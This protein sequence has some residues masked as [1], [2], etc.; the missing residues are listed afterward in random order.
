M[1]PPRFAKSKGWFLK[2]ARQNIEFWLCS[3]RM[4]RS[5]L[6]IGDPLLRQVAA[7]VERE[8]IWTPPFQTLIDDMIETMRSANGA[9][10]AAPQIGESVRLCI[11]EVVANERYPSMPALPLRI[12]I[13]PVL[14]VLS[15]PPEVLMYEGCL[16]VPGLRGRV[17]RPAHVRVRSLDRRGE[18]QVDEFRG[19]L[20]S[21]AAHEIDHLDGVL[22]VERADPKSF[23][24][25]DSFRRYV[26]V[27]ERILFFDSAGL[28][29]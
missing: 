8:A 29:T 11:L 9:G 13:N 20:A 17:R 5:I 4:E 6:Q 1:S 18:Q 19:P 15:Q 23:C 16:S 12:W 7:P 22:F 28:E 10:L 14:E 27:D 3:A 25:I 21:V 2:G 26:P 24:T